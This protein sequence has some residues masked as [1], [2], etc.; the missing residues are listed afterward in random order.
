MIVSFVEFK[1]KEKELDE[2][3]VAILK[4]IDEFIILNIDD[5]SNNNR[6]ISDFNSAYDFYVDYQRN[7]DFV[8]KFIYKD[9]RQHEIYF[10]NNQYKQLVEFM[11]DPELYKST[12]QYNL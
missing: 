10:T 8:V 3:K 7:S 11:E 1:N 2:Y 12:K 5:L 4:V 9:Y 6:Y